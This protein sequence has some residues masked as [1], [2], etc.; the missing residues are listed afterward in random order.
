MAG[1]ID[2]LIYSPFPKYSGGRENWLHNLS[3]QLRARGE[4][5]RAI[6]YA[7]NRPPFYSLDQSGIEVI[8]LPSI[9][10]FD[11]AFVLVNRVTLGL[12]K[13]L[14]LALFYPLI[15]GVHLRRA[16]P[17]TLVCM[18]SIPEGFVALVARVPFVVSVRSDVPKAL[19]GA[20]GFLER[21]LKWL[22]RR[23]LRGA[24]KVLANGQDTKERLAKAGIASTVVPNGV[25]F[26]RYSTPAAGDAVVAELERRARGKPVIAYV[27]TMLAIKGAADAVE[28]AAALKRRDADFMLA[29]VGKGNPGDFRRRAEALGLDDRVAFLGET[30]VVAA[31]L[32]RSSIFLGL[33]LE[34]GMSMSTLEAMA[35]GVP[36][37]ARYV[38]TY[39]QL[40]ENGVSGLLGATPAE[41]AECCIRL[42]R[43]PDLA[44]ALAVRAQDTAR[45]YDWPRVAEAF[46]A[47]VV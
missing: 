30:N 40:V 36:V 14:D 38:L 24:R 16:R 2:F 12:P 28:C 18:N 29:M 11:R 26:G 23:V 7:T 47:E 20:L 45:E 42:L 19:A 25:D 13:F 41:L 17:Q 6:S 1:P 21:P 46:L 32:Q 8:A 3:Q 34:N 9:R 10:Y 15:A 39:R 31:V 27:A 44:R 37:V 22:E 5:V 35:A 33:S 43:E 4:R